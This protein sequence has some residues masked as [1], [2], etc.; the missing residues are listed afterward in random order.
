MTWTYDVAMSSAKDRVRFYVGDTNS[1]DPLVEDEEI[2][3]MLDM[4]NS[5]V[6]KAAVDIAESIHMR[7][8]GVASESYGGLSV[9]YSNRAD[10]YEKLSRRLRIQAYGSASPVGAAMPYMG[11][12]SVSDKR[13]NEKNTDQVQPIFTR[14]QFKPEESDSET[15]DT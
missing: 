14:D 5:H 6:L 9:T 12:L 1:A 4:H 10:V 15:S 2:A 7:F 11:G 8:A 3:A 13:S